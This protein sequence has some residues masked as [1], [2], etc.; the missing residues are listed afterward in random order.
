MKYG[1]NR[2]IGI[3]SFA[4]LG[5]VLSALFSPI[6]L[7]R[8]YDSIRTSVPTQVA[9]TNTSV[10]EFD[11]V[12][13]PGGA[14]SAL[15]NQRRM[16]LIDLKDALGQSPS[17]SRLQD[18]AVGRGYRYEPSVR[19]TEER[20]RNEPTLQD[21]RSVGIG[22]MSNVIVDGSDLA[23]YV[24]RQ[25][26]PAAVTGT[27]ADDE[28]VRRGY[29]NARAPIT[30]IAMSLVGLI[31]GGFLGDL[32][33]RG[34]SLT[35]KNWNRTPVGGRVTIFLG[36]FLGILASIP[37]IFLFQGMGLF[38]PF[39]M[40]AMLIGFSALAVYTLR[41]MEQVLPWAG[42][43]GAKK[44]SGI[45]I[46]DTNVLIDGRIIDILKTGFIEGDLYV[47]EFVLQELQYIADSP[48]SLRRQRGRRG[49]KL[50]RS[51][52]AEFNVDVGSKDRY[53]GNPKEP[54]DTRLVRLA[55]AIGAD[56]V[57]NDFNLNGVAQVQD[58]KVLNINDLSLAVRTAILPGEVLEIHLIRDGQ[59]PGQAV[60]YLEDGTMVV[61]ES[62]HSHLGETIGVSVTQVL[63]TERGKMIFA[64]LPGEE[65]EE[66]A[67]RRGRSKS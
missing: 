53:A 31:I 29:P 23:V 25:V 10:Y 14:V 40:F 20:F 17:P 27:I 38:G 66:S 56:L 33:M 24:L 19:I 61:V 51:I 26:G 62:G 47:P 3:V 58:V 15:K 30:I 6:L 9:Q 21:L 5:A 64:S 57:S 59:Q 67:P 52:R 60:G 41:S 45:K 11:R 39:L 37:F 2:I 16:Q 13:D 34:L 46:L 49:L 54:V 55:K 8:I 43:S 48:D 35:K 7:D 4:I 42:M 32:G 65:D 18:L 1:Q 28:V 63:Q 22:S 12:V 50:L 44:R 36:V